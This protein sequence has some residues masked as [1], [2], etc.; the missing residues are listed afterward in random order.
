MDLFY[1]PT[2]SPGGAEHLLV[3]HDQYSTLIACAP[4]TRKR[5]A[6]DV[7][8]QFILLSEKSFGIH[9]AVV[10]S[11]QGGEFKNSAL[12]SFR[13]TRGIMTHFTAAYTP[14][15]NWTVERANRSIGDAART[16]L[17]GGGMKTKHWAEAACSFVQTWNA[18]ASEIFFWEVCMGTV[19]W[20][21]SSFST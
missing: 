5:D 20:S 9:V 4:L 21:V 11:D 12:Q 7:I 8:Q 3:L 2:P 19:Y 14:M 17:A 18:N 15:Q 6:S 16:M 10:H 1:W 13:T